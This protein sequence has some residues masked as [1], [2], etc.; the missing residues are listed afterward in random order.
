MNLVKKFRCI[1]CKRKYG[2][3]TF[4]GTKVI[5]SYC[6]FCIGK[7]KEIN[8]KPRAFECKRCK[9][10]ITPVNRSGY[11]RPCYTILKSRQYRALKLAKVHKCDLMKCKDIINIFHKPQNIVKSHDNTQYKNKIIINSVL[12]TKN[13]VKHRKTPQNGEMRKEKYNLSCNSTLDHRKTPAKRKVVS[14]K[15][16]LLLIFWVICITYKEVLL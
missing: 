2:T 13:I 1:T 9:T 8:P 16:Y 11:C 6:P 15:L 3:K 5:Q 4:W 7:G 14:V 12:R 10:P